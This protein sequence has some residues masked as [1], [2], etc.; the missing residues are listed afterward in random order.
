VV[1]E[2]RTPS[3][4]AG[5]VRVVDAGGAARVFTGADF[6]RALGYAELPSLWFDVLDGA[7]GTDGAVVL[8]GRGSGHGVGMCQ[9]GARGLAASGWTY[10]EILAHYYPG[11]EIR[12]MY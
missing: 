5:R 11:T 1:V 2:K 3:G 7:A 9:W 4:R 8:R 10:R 12:R 6:R